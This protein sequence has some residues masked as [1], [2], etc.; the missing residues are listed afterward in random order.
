MT[1]RTREHSLL[2][3]RRVDADGDERGITV[4]LVEEPIEVIRERILKLWRECDNWH[5][6]D[7]LKSAAAESGL[8]LSMLDVERD[9]KTE[10]SRG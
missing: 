10:A 4:E 5:H 2:W 7:L 9:R 8:V 3:R 6:W 1:N